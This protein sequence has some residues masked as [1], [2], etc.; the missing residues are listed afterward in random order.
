MQEYGRYNESPKKIK[1]KFNPRNLLVVVGLTLVV[2]GGTA[3]IHYQ[4]GDDIKKAN[5]NEYKE[6]EN[7]V[8][9][10]KEI[11]GILARNE[12]KN[13]TPR[14]IASL[15]GVLIHAVTVGQQYHASDDQILQ[16]MDRLA[17]TAKSRIFQDNAS[18]DS[19]L[20][21]V[22]GLKNGILY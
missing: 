20:G 18:G 17:G 16:V 6:L 9:F 3:M 15:E 5:M 10:Q 2:A 4:N 12:F 11:N 14:L 8:H 21:D 19:C 22:E 1:R 7:S 13:L